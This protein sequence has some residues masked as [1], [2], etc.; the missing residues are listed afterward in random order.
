VVVA[1]AFLSPCIAAAQAQS[2]APQPDQS[3]QGSPQ[4][5]LILDL[6]RLFDETA[7]GQ[8]VARDIETRA[9]ELA[10]ENRRIES[11]LIAEER[12]LTERRPTLSVE[13]FR[14]LADAFD[15]KVE[16]IREEQDG[17]TRDLQ[18]LRDVEQQRFF[19]QIGA[20]LSAIVRER[21]ASVVLDRRSV[22]LAVDAAD[23]TEEAI[24]RIDAEVGDGSDGE[25]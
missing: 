18:R 24:A 21:R 16:A 7:F 20:V 22:F 2:A 8:R 9:A 10:T 12:S 1:A 3:L 19:G 25:D 15:A 6:E 5:V 17:K 13:E 11:D 4:G 14:E 23:V